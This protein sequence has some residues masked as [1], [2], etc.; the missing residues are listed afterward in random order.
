MKESVSASVEVITRRVEQPFLESWYELADESHLWFRWR[1]AAALAQLRRL[2]LPLGRS[3]RALEVGCG[4]GVL[5]SQFEA[6]TSWTVDGADLDY[7]ALCRAAAA[8]RGRTLYYDIR[9][10]AAGLVEAYDV[11]ILYDVLEHIEDARPFVASLLRHLKPGGLLLVN[12]PAVQA[13]YGDYDR[14]AGHFRRYDKAGLAREFDGS[15]VEVVDMRYWGFGLL[16]LLLLRELMLKLNRRGSSEEV[17]RRGFRSPHP[18]V[19]KVLGALMRAESRVLRN[20]PLGSSL[21]MVCRKGA[22]PGRV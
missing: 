20:P 4:T 10:E 17:V 22:S 9:E 16:P 21:L 12:V 7:D 19:D 11:L 1:M 3:L 5:R 13:L 14:A 8:A 15:G 6:A 18:L 2:G